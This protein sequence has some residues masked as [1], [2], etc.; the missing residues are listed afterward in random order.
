MSAAKTRSVQSSKPEI[1]SVFQEGN[2][3]HANY[4]V[5]FVQK[6][7]HKGTDSLPHYRGFT[8]A[9]YFLRAGKQVNFQ[10]ACIAVQEDNVGGRD[11]TLTAFRNVP[12]SHKLCVR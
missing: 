7:S 10:A 1:P 9:R 12:G 4:S 6:Q 5:C 8:L 11:Q 3:S 2:C